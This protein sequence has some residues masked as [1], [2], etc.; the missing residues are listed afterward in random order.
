MSDERLY[1]R[2]LLAGRDYLVSASALGGNGAIAPLA[3]IAPKLLRR[4]YDLCRQQKFVEARG[5]QE[6]IAHLNHLVRE[7]GSSGLKDGLAGIKCAMAAMG[8]ECGLPRPPVRPLGEVERGR[9]EEA[10]QGLA[11]LKAEPRGW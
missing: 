10:V 9:F 1:I 3:G 2:Q 11:F 8:R 5:M 4:I 7:A 6:D